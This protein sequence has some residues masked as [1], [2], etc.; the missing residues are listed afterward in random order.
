[1]WTKRTVLS[2]L[3]LFA[4]MVA[5]GSASAQ[6]VVSES[7]AGVSVEPDQFYLGAHVDV[8]E[9]VERFWFRPNA[10]LGIGDGVT[11]VALN[12]EFVYKLRAVTTGMDSLFGG[13]T[14]VPDSV[15]SSGPMETGTPKSGRDS[16]SSGASGSKRVSWR[17]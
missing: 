15:F 4:F 14:C 13:R 11:V 2:C 10:E 3:F 12:G 1:M 9:I 5:A 8:K 7:G 16:T 6:S 17:D